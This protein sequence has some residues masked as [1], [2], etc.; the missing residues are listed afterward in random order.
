MKY[1]LK[2]EDR[3][4]D[5]DELMNKYGALTPVRNSGVFMLTFQPDF[6]PSSFVLMPNGEYKPVK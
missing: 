4:I 6:V 1:Y 2:S 5:K 3:I